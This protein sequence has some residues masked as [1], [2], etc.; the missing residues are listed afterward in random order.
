MAVAIFNGNDLTIQIPT[1][2]TFDAGRDLYS[3]WKQW[4]ALGDNA[5]F[6]K[7]FDTTG[8]DTVGAGQEI[9][10]Y[11]FCRNDL[12]WRVKMPD[13]N[14]EIIVQGNLFAR[15]SGSTLFE[16][17]PGFDAFF[18]LEVSTQALVVDG[19]GSG[20]LTPEQEATLNL[21]PALL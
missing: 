14:G 8:G 7:A 9:A 4:V 19:G 16:Q 13:A 10:P 5:K 11:F 20:G 12:G 1:T 2:G 18:R 3:A 6:P 21:I 15:D 17:S